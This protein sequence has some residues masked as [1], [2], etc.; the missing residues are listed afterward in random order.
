MLQRSDCRSQY[1]GRPFVSKFWCR[2]CSSSRHARQPPTQP[3]L[4]VYRAGW[5]APIAVR[6]TLH[7]R[8][9]VQVKGDRGNDASGILLY[10]HIPV[11]V[12]AV[13]RLSVLCQRTKALRASPL[14]R[15]TPVG[16][17]PWS[18]VGA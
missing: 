3:S 16:R 7:L 4:N 11:E 1:L 8:G 6:V 9:L 15:G 10:L 13:R 17:L 18:D 12:V 14:L 5:V 2:S